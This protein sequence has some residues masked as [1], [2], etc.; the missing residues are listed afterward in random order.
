MKSR[1]EFSI[2]GPNESSPIP[3][4]CKAL[5]T[6]RKNC[7]SAL[8]MFGIHSCTVNNTLNIDIDKQIIIVFPNQIRLVNSDILLTNTIMAFT[9]FWRSCIN[10]WSH[11]SMCS[12]TELTMVSIWISLPQI[13]WSQH[14]GWI[15]TLM[16]IAT[17]QYHQCR[18][19]SMYMMTSLD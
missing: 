15:I 11:H 19:V 4:P 16:N 6:C 17:Y 2:N 7:Y 5:A 1:T 8:K 3:Y 14:W 18:M 12:S 10:K 9:A 13:W